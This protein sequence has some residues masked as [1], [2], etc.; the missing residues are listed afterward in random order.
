MTPALNI[1]LPRQNEKVTETPWHKII[2]AG[3]V[4]LSRKGRYDIKS[5]KVSE[6]CVYKYNQ[7]VNEEY[8]S[9]VNERTSIMSRT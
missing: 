5:I 9:A 8:P 3:G 4:R 1:R 7:P 2:Q 6:N